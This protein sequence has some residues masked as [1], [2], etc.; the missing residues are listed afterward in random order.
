MDSSSSN[1]AAG[2]RDA[3]QRITFDGS[4]LSFDGATVGGFDPAEFAI[5]APSVGG[6]S[7]VIIAHIGTARWGLPRGVRIAPGRGILAVLSESGRVH[8]LVD[9]G[10]RVREL[11]GPL[12]FAKRIR[13]EM[14]G[15]SD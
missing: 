9:R 11:Q 2:A 3:F 14:F 1:L 5:A 10:G 12:E 7:G 6:T 4:A 8:V 15:T 13:R